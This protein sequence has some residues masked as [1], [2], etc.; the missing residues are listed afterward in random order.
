WVM[1]SFYGGGHGGSPEGDGLNHGNAPISTAT[2]PPMEILESAY[3]VMFKQ[4]ALRPDSAGAGQHRGGM[5][6]SY[7]IEVLEESATAFLFG[8]RGRFAPKGV[9]GGG[10]AA[11]NRFE[12]EQDDGWHAPPMASKMVGI[13]LQRGQ[14]VRLDTPGG[15][16]YGAPANRAAADVAR[17]V[18][19][20]LLT[21]DYATQT[22]GPDWKE[23]TQ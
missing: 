11:L 5:G 16:G 20:G 9:A 4:W 14:S 21:P 2:I 15:G 6:A 22:Y 8:E 7:E 19:G 23:V 10:D 17:D 3:P 13:K 1:F 18:A 12:Y